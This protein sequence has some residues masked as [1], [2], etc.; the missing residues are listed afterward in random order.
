MIDTKA[1]GKKKDE[2]KANESVEYTSY[3]ADM[4]AEAFN[5]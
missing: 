1:K 4:V 3:S 5:W 2:K